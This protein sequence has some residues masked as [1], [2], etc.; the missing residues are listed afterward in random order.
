MRAH[1]IAGAAAAVLG[2]V[3]VVPGIAPADIGLNVIPTKSEIATQP[4]KTET[5]PVT[6]RNDSGDV[7][8]VQAS[9][10][11][12]TIAPNG[13][14][15]FMQAGKS[16][17]SLAPYL[18]MNPREFDIPAGQLQQVRVSFTL[19]EH[20]IGEYATIVFFQTRPVRR[21]G[22]I[23]F[24]ERIASKIY[25]MAGDTGQIGGVVDDVSVQP[26]SGGEKVVVGFKNN[27]NVHEYVNGRVEIKKAGAVVDKFSL[28]QQQLV[29]RGDRVVLEAQ[30]KP[31]PAGQYDAVAIC[32][33]GGTKLTGGQASFTVH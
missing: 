28:A 20:K 6:V 5:F 2:F 18:S 33:Y 31:L 27:G 8:H 1:L 10:S 29:E 11:D 3:A 15:V 4:G 30:G 32:D 14:H 12:F 22:A 16:P 24:S 19:P 17:Y 7:I 21:P 25:A 13:Q 23:G 9:L 26:Q